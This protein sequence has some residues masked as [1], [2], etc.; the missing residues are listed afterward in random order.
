[1]LGKSH[2]CMFMNYHGD[3]FADTS[4]VSKYLGDL[5]EREISIRV[6]TNRLRHAIVTYFK[7]IDES[8]DV[9]V[10]ESLATLM[11]HT[12]RYQRE[13]YDDTT[14]D[15]K[16]RK[17]R[18]VIRETLTTNVFGEKDDL[19]QSATGGD[20]NPSEAS[21]GELELLPN[22][23]DICALLDSAS[24]SK[25]ICFF[26]GKIARFSNERQ[27]VHLMH[28]ERVDDSG[29]LYRIKPGSVWKE[30]VNSLVF[31]VDIVYNHTAEGYELRTSPEE[32]YKCVHK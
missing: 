26:L 27:D 31:P 8:N 18:N 3:P 4:A 12:V 10:R 16:T 15:S 21:D 28:L 13:V 17:A 6:G 19:V 20:D 11:K 25:N 5:F 30:S 22:V 29:N 2:E 1:M 9:T 7:S 14:H 23:G 24:S 32:I